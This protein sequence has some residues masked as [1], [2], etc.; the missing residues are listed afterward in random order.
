MAPVYKNDVIC[1]PLNHYPMS[2][3]FVWCKV[4]ERVSVSQIANYLESGLMSV[5]QFGFRKGNQLLV[6]YEEIV[7]LVDRSFVA[8]M[9]F[10]IL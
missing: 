3:T 7:K 5:K 8:D 6:T 1:D 2:H 4:L 9:I 10:L